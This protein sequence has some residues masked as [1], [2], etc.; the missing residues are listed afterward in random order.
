MTINEHEKKNNE[1]RLKKKE[2]LINLKK[3]KKNPVKSG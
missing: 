3:T 2:F 1:K